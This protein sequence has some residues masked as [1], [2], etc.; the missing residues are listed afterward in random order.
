MKTLTCKKIAKSI[1]ESFEY[2]CEISSKSILII[3][4]YTV[5][6]LHVFLSTNDYIK[7]IN[8]TIGRDLDFGFIAAT[9]LPVA[10]NTNDIY[11]ISLVI[12][13]E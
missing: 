9:W 5:S 12:S 7:V 3:L 13:G 11:W 2:F 6:N 10:V 4:R 8:V 1:L